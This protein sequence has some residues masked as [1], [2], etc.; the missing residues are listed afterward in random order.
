[1]KNP[2][3]RPIFWIFFLISCVMNWGTLNSVQ[4]VVRKYFGNFTFDSSNIYPLLPHILFPWVFTYG[5][6]FLTYN[7][8]YRAPSSRISISKLSFFSSPP[9]LL[10]FLT[11]NDS[12]ST[13]F[14]TQCPTQWLSVSPSYNFFLWRYT[15][16][17]T[18]YIIFDRRD[19]FQFFNEYGI[20][21]VY[22]DH[23]PISIILG[24]FLL[25]FT[26]LA[27]FGIYI[28]VLGLFTW[29]RNH[30]QPISV[31]KV[32][33]FLLK[34]SGVDFFTSLGFLKDYFILSW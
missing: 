31:N 17:I 19:T 2:Y 27:N 21:N 10:S 24:F 33:F 6:F 1:M 8:F 7:A 34:Y 9:S 29:L 3:S 18:F 23:T 13:V 26:F 12:A 30:L 4:H 11:W 15:K 14:I 28:G 32:W 25:F 16:G 5:V 20:S 22:N